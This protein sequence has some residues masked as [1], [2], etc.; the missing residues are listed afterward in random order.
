MRDFDDFCDEEW[1]WQKRQAEMEE[2][3]A[4]ARA[5]CRA[6]EAQ[7]EEVEEEALPPERG[8]YALGVRDQHEYRRERAHMEY[9]SEHPAVN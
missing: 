8:A 4:A 9:C 2:A 6:A 7:A 3:Q 5:A 1:A